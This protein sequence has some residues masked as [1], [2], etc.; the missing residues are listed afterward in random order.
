[1]RRVLV[2][3]KNMQPINVIPEK[4]AF[5][6]IVAGKAEVVDV[7]MATWAMGFYGLED[8]QE[9]SALKVQAEELRDDEQIYYENANE[10]IFISPAIIRVEYKGLPNRRVRL[11]RRNIIKRDNNV[12]QYCYKKFE[13][14]D[15][16]V[17]HV[18]PKA[19]GGKNVWTNLVCSCISCNSKKRDR[20]PTEA[21][22]KLLRD[23]FRP[24]FEVDLTRYIHKKEYTSWKAFLSE[25]YWEV[26]LIE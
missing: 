21:G 23:P 11:N 25:K 2:L 7:D 16:N 12:C 1:M 20:T 6:K 26:E 3:N 5:T 4:K 22:M 17:D 19:Q 10:D 18:K 9:L 24:M 13:T 15:L 8:W 14:K